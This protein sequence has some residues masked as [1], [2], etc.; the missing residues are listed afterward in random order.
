MLRSSAFCFHCFLSPPMGLVFSWLW[1]RREAAPAL[2]DVAAEAQ[3]SVKPTVWPGHTDLLNLLP[4]PSHSHSHPQ[5]PHFFFFPSPG[6]EVGVSLAEPEH[7]VPACS[8]LRSYSSYSPPPPTPPP[9]TPHILYPLPSYNFF[10]PPHWLPFPP[11]SKPFSHIPFV[12]LLVSPHI[13]GLTRH[14]DSVIH[15]YLRL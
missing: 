12:R 1:G 6:A 4:P 7:F 9:I 13:I 11:P 8:F 3:V 14:M 5:P 10:A 15:L 2:P